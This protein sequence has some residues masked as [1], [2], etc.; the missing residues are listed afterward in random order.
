MKLTDGDHCFVIVGDVDYIKIVRGPFALTQACD[1]A[2]RKRIGYPNQRFKICE[3][4]FC[5]HKCCIIEKR[6][7]YIGCDTDLSCFRKKKGVSLV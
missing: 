7:I 1:L 3:P 5:E 4:R 2:A 6:E